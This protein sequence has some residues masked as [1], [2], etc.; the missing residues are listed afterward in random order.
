MLAKVAGH[1][2]RMMEFTI[3]EDVRAFFHFYWFPKIFE[4]NDIQEQVPSFQVFGRMNWRADEDG[5]TVMIIPLAELVLSV[6]HILVGT[7]VT[8]F[9]SPLLENDEENE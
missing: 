8:S 9:S 7:T 5:E 3:E 1:F 6:V 2:D 4:N